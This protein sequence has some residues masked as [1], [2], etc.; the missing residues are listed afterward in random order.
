MLAKGY[1]TLQSVIVTVTQRLH[2]TLWRTCRVLANRNR[3]RI[4]GCLLQQPD[5]TVTAVANRLRL[6]VA[7]ASQYLRALEARSLL[8]ARRKGRYVSYRVSDGERAGA[9]EALVAALRTVFQREHDP[10]TIVFKLAT[11][12]TH[13]RR[14]A[15]IQA[16]AG[17]AQTLQELH[18]RTDISFPALMRHLAKLEARG[19]MMRGNGIYVLVPQRAPLPRALATMACE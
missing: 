8:V 13:P 14:V 9:V 3:L 10:I 16:L 15:V 7:V 12:F 17:G 1:H 4:F 2:P 6:P 11:A 19:L 18:D 5:Q